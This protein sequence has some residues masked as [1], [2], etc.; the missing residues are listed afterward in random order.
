MRFLC[1]SLVLFLT[2]FIAKPR[3]T[4]HPIYVSVLDMEHNANEQTLEISC[5]IFTN[6]FET[7]LRKNAAHKLDLINPSDKNEAEKLVSDYIRKHIKINIDDK[8]VD[9]GFLGYE[10]ADESIESY[11]QVDNVKSV[12]KISVEDDILYEYKS[13]QMGIIHALVNKVRK[14]IRLNNPEKKAVFEF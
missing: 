6:D 2:S 3:I 12:K 11:F 10:K 7:V 13:E 5:K 8:P 9:M 14:S 4:N 1:F